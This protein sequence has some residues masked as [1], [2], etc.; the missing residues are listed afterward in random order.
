MVLSLLIAVVGAFG[1][2]SG[3]AW[4]RWL[5]VAYVEAIRNT[6]FLVQIFMI[7]FGLPTVGVRLD[8]DE[9]R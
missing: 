7:F 9:A 2:T 5:I 8:A 4:V 6:P 1:R 3:P